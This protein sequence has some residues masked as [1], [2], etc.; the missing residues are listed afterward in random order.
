M[1]IQIQEQDRT[2]RDSEA[3]VRAVLDAALSAVV[4]IDHEGRII[5]WNPRAEQIFGWSRAEALGLDLASSIIPPEQRDMH[6]QGMHRYRQHGAGPVLNRLVE[7]TAL[8]RDG[9]EFPVELSISPLHS[10]GNT[11][12]CGFIT[13]ITE[14]KQA[15]SKLQEQLARLDL[16]HRITRAIGE[17]LDLKSIF[18]VV[19]RTLEHNLPVDFGCICLYSPSEQMLTVTSV[20]VNSRSLALELAM[21]EQ[22]RV[23]VDQNGLLRC[24]QG[25]LIYE[26]DI[27]NGKFPFPLRLAKSGLS[28]L[29]MAPLLAESKVF[30]V[31]VAARRAP[32]SFSSGDCEFLRQL[33]EHVALAAHQTQLY[34]DLQQAYDE[35]RHS[36][37]LTL[38]QERLRALGQMASGVAHDINNAI[39]PV[40]LYTESLLER[41]PNLS[42]RARMYL[43][44]IQRAVEDVAQTVSRMREFYRPRESQLSLTP[45]N[46]NQIVMQV[47]ELTRAKWR[48][49]PQQ[50]GVVIELHAELAPVLPEVMGAE[51]EI[52]D[53][54]TNLIFNAVDAMPEGGTLTIRTYVLRASDLAGVSQRVALEVSDTGIG[55]DEPTRRQCLEPFFTTKGERG[56]GMGLAMVYG[57]TQRHKAEFQID[58]S[59]GSGTIMRCIFS[60]GSIAVDA[61]DRRRVAPPAAPLSILLVDDDPLIIEAMQEILGRDGHRI[62]AVDGGQAGIDAFTRALAQRNSGGAGIDVV[63]TDLGMPHIDG[64]RVAAAIKALS[65]TVPVIMLT[66]WGQRLL[67]D[68]AVPPFVDRV[69]S[70]PPK[71]DELR[72]TLTELTTHSHAASPS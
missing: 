25:E 4:L 23:P 22:A 33:S 24:V 16:L 51:N 54:L 20:G 58:S 30:G 56:T 9:S 49:V 1:L 67:D 43:T 52:R 18:Q 55:M 64:R 50:H 15:D 8:R 46:L 72:R 66:G 11:T 17:R 38:Q 41:E 2:V 29:V 3:R 21:T 28:A 19:I 48:D 71:L 32:N 69:L 14:R 35:L 34:T 31:L 61:V 36:Q 47:S 45:I 57:M 10:G 63:I 5:E 13:D 27:R 62:T 12:F 60:A 42:E 44:T 37:Q 40:T 70:K 39:S 59:P 6:R 26:P 53:A 68:G 65:P 7:L